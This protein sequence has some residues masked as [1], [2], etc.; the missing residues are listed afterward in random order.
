MSYVV[1]LEK[2]SSYDQNK[3]GISLKKLVNNLG[4]IQKFIKKGQKVLLKPNVVKG[5]APEECG[6]THPAV[7]GAM[8]K[9]LKEQNCD[10]YVGDA[11]FVDDTLAAMKICGIYDVC[12][13]HDA[14]MAVF[15]RKETVT[16]NNLI[17]VKKFPLTGY[18]NEVDAVINI[19]KLKTH[20]QLYFTGAVKNL[21]SIMPG[22]RRGFYHL[23]YSNMEYFAN[24]LLDLYS[25]LRKKVVLS[26]MDGIY[27]MEG[28]GPCGGSP[29]FAGMLGASTDAVAL[30]FVMCNMIG[31]NTSNLPTIY[32]AKKRKDYLFDESKIRLI[33]EKIRNIRI[34]HFKEAE[35][36]TLNMMPKFVNNFKEYV[37]RHKNELA[38]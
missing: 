17:V 22:P 20:A 21:Y 6:T 3:I 4:G 15:D 25:I 24:M 32:Y 35:F 28:N 10:V 23:K 26:I 36:Q 7:V 5:M 18:F 13:K 37:T 19:P 1:S 33:G 12:E 16:N 11:P 34:P 14:K 27:G 31:L 38:Y 2:C 8:I 9:I 30:D 29:K